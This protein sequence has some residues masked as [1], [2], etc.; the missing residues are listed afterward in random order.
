[1]NYLWL[2]VI[3]RTTRDVDPCSPAARPHPLPGVRVRL[4]YHAIGRLLI[5]P[6]LRSPYGIS[7]NVCAAGG[8]VAPRGGQNNSSGMLGRSIPL[9]LKPRLGGEVLK[10]PN[11][12]PSNA[13]PYIIGA[14]PVCFCFRGTR[15]EEEWGY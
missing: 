6:R 1:M 4:L 14:A 10:N 9:R 15:A 3:S 8:T 11:Q 13:G 5:S 2:G 12:N 7:V